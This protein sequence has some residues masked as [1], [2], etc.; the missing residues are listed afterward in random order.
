MMEEFET[1]REEENLEEEEI[2]GVRRRGMPEMPM[3]G[4]ALRFLE[5]NDRVLLRIFGSD[6]TCERLITAVGFLIL[7]AVIDVGAPT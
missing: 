7:S 3:L 2:V 4:A 5:S 6:G 1:D